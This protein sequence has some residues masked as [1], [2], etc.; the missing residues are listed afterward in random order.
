MIVRILLLLALLFL[1]A[2][3]F[4][5]IAH[6]AA[7]EIHNNIEV[8]ERYQGSR[9][10]AYTAVLLV[11]LVIIGIFVVVASILFE[12]HQY[13]KGAAELKDDQDQVAPKIK[14]GSLEENDI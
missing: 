12:Y 6:R 9:P 13:R 3:V 5:G 8:Y 7:T 11:A 10:A 14:P 4:W 2:S 1:L